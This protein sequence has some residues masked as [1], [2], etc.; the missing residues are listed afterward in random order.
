MA[1]YFVTS[2]L[3][4]LSVFDV[5][6]PRGYAGTGV[7]E[8][9][10]SYWV[11]RYASDGTV[12]PGEVSRTAAGPATAAVALAVLALPLAVALRR[13]ATTVARRCAG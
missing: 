1:P 11:P 13:R 4:S 12:R 8:V 5:S 3:E 2:G 9:W 7:C 6:D 10:D